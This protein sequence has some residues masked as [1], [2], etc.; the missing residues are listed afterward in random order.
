[1]LGH[2]G[3]RRH[4]ILVASLLNIVLICQ[5]LLGIHLDVGHVGW[6]MRV[7]RYA[8]PACL[9]RQVGGRVLWR[10]DLA[11]VHPVFV[12]VT[13]FGRIQ[14]GLSD[15]SQNIVSQVGKSSLHGRAPTWIKFLP[16][17]LVT[18]GWSLGVVKV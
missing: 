5:G 10:V 14:A 8:G 18:R 12:A 6:H 15:R 11:I 16:S 3:L 17:A 7:L 2:A 1:M 13:R 4:S 9:G